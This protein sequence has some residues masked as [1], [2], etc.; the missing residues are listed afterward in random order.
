ML[1]VSLCHG[2]LVFIRID[3]VN[4]LLLFF[5]CFCLIWLMIIVELSR[6]SRHKRGG[7]TKN[8]M[9]KPA[10]ERS[11]QCMKYA[12]FQCICEAYLTHIQIHILFVRQQWL[13]LNTFCFFHILANFA[14]ALEDDVRV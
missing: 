9:R 4:R 3:L 12:I 2:F 14:N 1:F 13:A 6:H 11:Q 7:R 8:L 10:S 5:F